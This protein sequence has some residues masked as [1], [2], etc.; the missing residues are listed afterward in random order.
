MRVLL[1]N[2]QM[3]LLIGRLS[4]YEAVLGHQG[5]AND[6]QQEGLKVSI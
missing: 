5:I 4:L 1:A 2:C 3:M 6:L